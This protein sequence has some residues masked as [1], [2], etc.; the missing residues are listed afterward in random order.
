MIMQDLIIL[1][2]TNYH[3]NT[4]LGVTHHVDVTVVH[5]S[6]P[7]LTRCHVADSFSRCV[8]HTGAFAE[9]LPLL[10]LVHVAYGVL[11]VKVYR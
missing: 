6:K 10:L 4:M 1:T 9:F 8:I 11:R 7:R 5:I 2:S 3:A